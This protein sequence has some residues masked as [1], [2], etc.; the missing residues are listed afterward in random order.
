MRFIKYNYG[1]WEV[2]LKIVAC[3]RVQK[4]VVRHKYYICIFYSVHLLEIRTESVVFSRLIN[5]FY[6]KGAPFEGSR[7]SEKLWIRSVIEFALCMHRSAF[8][9]KPSPS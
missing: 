6:I 9:V 1:T 7:S 8:L 2:D 5:V 3:R 4:V